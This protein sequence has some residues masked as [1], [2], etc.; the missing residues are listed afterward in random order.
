MEDL[1]QHIDKVIAE[2][3]SHAKA[4]REEAANDLLIVEMISMIEDTAV[5]ALE[6]FKG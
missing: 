4:A 5:S 3:R 2:V 6:Q 1:K